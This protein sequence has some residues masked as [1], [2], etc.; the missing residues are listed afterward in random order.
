MVEPIPEVSI[1][2]DT[3]KCQ[4]D[5]LYIYAAV[6]PDWYTLYS[7]QWSP[8]NSISNDTLPGIV[9]NGP[10]DISLILTVT[11][12]ADCRASDTI[13]ITVHEG[14]FSSLTPIDTTICPHDSVFYEVKGGVSY[15]WVPA[16]YLDDGF[17]ATPAS[18]PVTD[19][20]YTVFATDQYGCNDTV[21]AS[22]AVNPEAVIGLEDSLNLYPG[23]TIQLSPRG[24]CLYFTWF[25]PVGLSAT[26]ISNPI[27]VPVVNTRYYVAGVTEAGCAATDSINV[28]VSNES[29]LEIPNAFAPGS[30]PNSD[31]KILHRGKATLGYFRVFNRYGNLVFETNNIDAGWDGRYS[32]TLQPVGAYLYTIEAFTNTGRRFYKQGNVTLIR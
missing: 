4:W 15:E 16:L 29:L 1:V 27:A 31:L 5:D 30:G 20:A 6:S 14:N 25:P 26:D 3:S 12:L 2:A 10:S 11:T 9:F 13:N 23:E 19:V 32:G 18:I 21:Y 24:N 17:A 8:N 22:I 28:I 7:Y